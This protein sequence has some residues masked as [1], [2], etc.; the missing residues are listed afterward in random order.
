MNLLQVPID[1]ENQI[2]WSEMT[3]QKWPMDLSSLPTAILEGMRKGHA[4]SGEILVI[5][6]LL[7]I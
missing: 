2:H 1:S 4:P 3:G 6:Y 7:E 5:I